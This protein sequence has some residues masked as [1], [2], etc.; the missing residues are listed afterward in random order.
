MTDILGRIIEHK[1]E[2]VA[3]LRR[4]FSRT[5]LH[6]LAAGQSAP[7]GFARALKECVAS[8]RAAVI[9]EIKRASP[10]RGLIRP[11]G[12]SGP[13]AGFNPA[14]LAGD[15]A[16]GGAAALSVLTDARFFL[17]DNEHLGA[18]RAA[19]TLPALR[20]D[21]MVDEMQVAESRALGADCILLIAAALSAAQM[22]ELAAAA[23]EQHM[24]VLVEVHDRDELGQV[25][26]ARLGPVMVGVNNRDLRTFETRLETTLDLLPHLPAGSD[27]V[28]ESGIGSAADVQR[29]RA[30]GVHRF[31]VGESLMRAE[32]PGAALKELLRGN[33]DG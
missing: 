17:G 10:S 26:A 18:A 31:L 9:A 5:A 7:R 15:Y 21:F 19:C 13:G 28:T 27:V 29:L 22:N 11:E 23:I 24:D 2:E 8:G 30:A 6:D 3:A 16:Q 20:K 12:G 1:R 25:L 33:A 14:W 4:K 32:S